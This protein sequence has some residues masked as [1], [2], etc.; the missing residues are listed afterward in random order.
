MG[1]NVFS[2]GFVN[3]NTVAEQGEF[4]TQEGTSRVEICDTLSSA[5]NFITGSIDVQL[6][7]CKI[8]TVAGQGALSKDN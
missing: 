8:M 2:E 6:D 5:V 3:E 1:R 4:K 7:V